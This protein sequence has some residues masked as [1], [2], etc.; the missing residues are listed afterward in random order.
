[1]SGFAGPAID[2][3]IITGPSGTI[4]TNQATFTFSGSPA[5][6]TA[7]IQCRIDSELLADC[8]S[9]KAFTDLAEGPHTATFRTEDAAGNR[10]LTPATLT[11]T[12]DTTPPDTQISSGPSGTITTDEATFAFAGD[13]GT[14]T[15]KIQC[16][17]D[18]GTFAD[19]ASPRTFSGL[20]DGL[21]TA[22]FRA[23]DAAGNQDPTPASRTF[24][25]DTTV[26][27][28]KIGRVKVSGPA[29]VKRKRKATY[30][31]TISNSGN[32]VATGVRL[33]VSGR[34][35]KFKAPVGRIPAGKSRTVRVSARLKRRGRI[36]VSFRVTSSDAGSRTVRTKITV[37]K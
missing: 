31:V 29:K 14:D 8:E 30:N 32:A 37:R 17:I 36:T 33:R 4:T 11:F 5:E 9:P 21:H 34:G 6:S 35:I 24:T 15:A 27:R 1:L 28:A 10:D 23:E 16:R 20:T 22:T 13:P 25:V 19:C 18:S 2:T 3:T 7:K 12:V 26:F